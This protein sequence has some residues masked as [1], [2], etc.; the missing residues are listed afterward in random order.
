MTNGL[1]EH[2][3]LFLQL[4]EKLVVFLILDMALL[5]FQMKLFPALTFPPMA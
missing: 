5:A 3:Y 4:S 2:C 1:A